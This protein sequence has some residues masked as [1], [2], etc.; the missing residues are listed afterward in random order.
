[1]SQTPI[2]ENKMGTM[3]VLPLITNMAVPMMLSMVITALYN[4]VDGMFVSMISENAFTA[5][6]LTYPLQNLMIALSIG[7]GVGVN[8]LASRSMGRGDVTQAQAV[9][10]NGLFLTVL[11]SLLFV[12]LGLF[13]M[14]P[15]YQSQTDVAEIVEF[16]VQYGGICCTFA[17]GW[18][19]VITFERVLQATGRTLYCMYVQGFG[20]IINLILDPIL[21]FGYFG[22]PEMGVVGAAL[23]TVLGQIISMFLALYLCLRKN[24]ELPL[25]IQG[26]RPDK[27]I[28]KGIYKIGAPSIVMQAIGSVMAYAMNLMLLTF[29]TTAAAVLGAYVKVMGFVFMPVY[30]LSNA[31]IPIV[32]YNY[33][34]KKRSRILETLQYCCIIA[35]AILG[36]G[37]VVFLAIPHMLMGF[38]NPT[39]EMM[40]LGTT[41]LRIISF[42][43][44]PAAFCLV[45][46]TV[47]QGLGLATY[48]LISSFVRQLVVLLPVAYWLGVHYGLGAIW[49]AFPIAEGVAVVMNIWF[50]YHVLQRVLTE[51]AMNA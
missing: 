24:P 47:F 3:P 4:V 45:V 34:A 1:M 42:S 36:T 39:E 21:I 33:G 13:T 37:M 8:A 44:V 7:T 31:I 14:R 23:A 49:W 16:G 28:I 11:R 6:S 30:G 19:F 35:V 27:D 25:N 18:F 10:A 5:V 46:G 32:A 22:L 20:A 41:A 50:L 43:F 26:F 29:S 17:F 9:C 12:A 2:R 51:D 38:F 48:S 40:N 15:F